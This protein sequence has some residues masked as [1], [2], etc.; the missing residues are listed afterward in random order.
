MGLKIDLGPGEIT[1]IG[2]NTILNGNK[3]A[4]FYVTGP[5]PILKARSIMKPEDVDTPCKRVYLAVQNVYTG[6]GREADIAEYNE[7]R[8]KVLEHAPATQAYFDLITH[9]LQEGAGYK[10]LAEAGNL[11]KYEESILRAAE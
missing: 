9:H 4:I 3:R 6:G 11:I 2:R 5:D 7:A 1:M 10:A 8:R